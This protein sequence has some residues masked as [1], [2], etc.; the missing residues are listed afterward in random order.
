VIGGANAATTATAAAAF[1]EPRASGRI[2]HAAS[3]PTPVA[4]TASGTLSTAE[5]ISVVTNGL[6]LAAH[7][8]DGQLR[9]SDIAAGIVGAVVRDPL[10][11]E[12]AWREYLEG[13][14]RDRD[15][16][17]DFYEACRELG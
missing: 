1:Q 15:G 16:W 13:V 6:A 17:G 4:R 5:A 10:H 14:V 2:N 11:D 9:A 8:G 3:A 12:V 7:F